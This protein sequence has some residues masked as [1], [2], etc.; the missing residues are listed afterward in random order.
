MTEKKED[1]IKKVEKLEKEL[2]ETQTQFMKLSEG[3]KELI[4]ANSALQGLVNQY[5]VTINMLT[6]RVIQSQQT[7][8]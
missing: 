1:L 4:G 5:E 7:E 2:T 8:G 6:A 3:Y